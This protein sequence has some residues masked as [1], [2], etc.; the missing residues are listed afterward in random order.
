LR[1]YTA[2]EL[3]KRSRLLLC[4]RGKTYCGK[5]AARAYES[6]IHTWNLTR[7][8]EPNHALTIVRSEVLNSPLR[9]CVELFLVVQQP[10]R[11]SKPLQ[12][13]RRRAESQVVH[14][15][16]RDLKILIAQPELQRRRHGVETIQR[17]K[18]LLSQESNE[19]DE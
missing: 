15:V 13:R 8:T 6:R 3:S 11:L 16:T 19:L 17:R 12:R 5:Q 14:V 1:Y 7:D 4:L 10:A 9:L 2:A 18:A